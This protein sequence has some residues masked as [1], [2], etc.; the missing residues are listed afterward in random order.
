MNLLKKCGRLSGLPIARGGHLFPGMSHSTGRAFARFGVRL[1][2]R[3]GKAGQDV[4]RSLYCTPA[5]PKPNQILY[6]NHYRDS[7]RGILLYSHIGCIFLCMIYQ[8]DPEFACRPQ[9]RHGGCFFLAILRA[10]S[11]KFGL[12]FTHLSMLDFYGREL[13]DS[14]TDVDNEM[15]IGNAQDLIDDYLGPGKVHYLGFAPSIY[16]A[17]QSEIEW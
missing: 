12:P 5:E 6:Y 15:F 3:E 14:D 7:A 2:S 10:L 1:V 16:P 4:C 13:A 17:K 8:T 9:I 11:D